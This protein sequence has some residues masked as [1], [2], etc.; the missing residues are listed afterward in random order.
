[1]QTAL[2]CIRVIL[3]ILLSG[4]AN[5]Q[6]GYPQKPLRIIVGFQPGSSSDVAARIV[7]Q[8]LGPV[9]GQNVVVENR[10]GASSG[11]AARAVATS[12]A[13]GHVLFFATVA[14]VINT[15]A[16][17]PTDVDIARDL[18]PLAMVGRV[19]NILVLN[20]ELGIESL[21]ALIRRLKY[22]PDHIAYGTAGNGTA[23]HLAAALFSV[24]ADVRM[25]HV[26]YQG[27]AAAI[28]DLLAGRI[29]VMFAPASSVL[30]HVRAGR[31]TAIAS[32][33]STRSSIAPDLPTI[34]ELGLKGFE[35]TVWFGIAAPLRLPARTEGIL[36]SAIRE[37]LLSEEVQSQF[38]VNGIETSILNLGDFGDYIRAETAKWARVIKSQGI[39]LH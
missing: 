26:P 23:I 16:N 5:A 6:D 18:L 38:K 34:A 3:L 20:P 22:Q 14:N 25:V 11:I 32:T 15:A 8:K 17:S 12:P 37:A 4:T 7:A 9:I 1:M 10:A 33:G 36:V 29:W 30:P 13:D 28:T 35:S 39:R 2:D 31:L 19:P 21:D 27:S 24:M